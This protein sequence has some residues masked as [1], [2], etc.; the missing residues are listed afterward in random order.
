MNC[1]VVLIDSAEKP[2]V[3]RK[4]FSTLTTFF[5]KPGSPWTYSVRHVT[6]TLANGKYLPEDKSEEPTLALHALSALSHERLVALLSFCTALAEESTRY[7]T[8]GLALF[9]FFPCFLTPAYASSSTESGSRLQA[10]TND[11]FHLIDYGFE[12]AVNNAGS[13]SNQNVTDHS[14]DVAKESIQTLH[15]CIM[16]PIQLRFLLFWC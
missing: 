11:V 10:N 16:C 9:P 15:V 6:V 2:L 5:F 7:L 1:F 4:F 3:M 12:R 13:V 14:L 8:E